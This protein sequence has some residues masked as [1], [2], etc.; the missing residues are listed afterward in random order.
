MEV[1]NVLIVRFRQLGDAVLTTVLCNTI[2]KNFPHAHIDFVL[3][4]NLAPLFKDHPSIDRIIT[5][6]RD[7]RTNTLTY[8]R[9]IWRIVHETH[10]DVIID[11]RST[12]NTVPFALFS[13]H[14]PIRVA[15]KKTYTHLVYNY[16][17]GPVGNK[18]MID[19]ILEH[20]KPLE[21]I[22]HLEYDR[23][24]TLGITEQEKKAFRSYLEHEG[25]SLNRPI[26]L[27]GVTA[28]LEE[29]TW[30]K[31]RITEVIARFITTFPQVQIIFNYA[32]GKEEENAR[33]IYAKLDYPDNVY[34]NVQAR[35]SR[36]LAAMCSSIDLY[37][38]NEGGARHI[39]H[40]MQKPSLVVCSPF[41]NPHVWIPQ[42]NVPAVAINNS[43]AT[44]ENVWH[45]LES[46]TLQHI[47]HL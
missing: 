37:F 30:P 22:R 36:E 14:T 24:M 17:V 27:M 10:Y 3:N 7:E 9:K 33:D 29:K 32:P 4:E 38:G 13:L 20:L 41:A 15:L 2:R 18:P 28:K 21:R 8:L 12:L 19:H 11:K 25:L 43:D 45:E 44:I 6:S 5:F 40:A 26:A 42:D 16:R 1:K 47:H 23:Q 39:V 31:E 34:I 46:F 35:S